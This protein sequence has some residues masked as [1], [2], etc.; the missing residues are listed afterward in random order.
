VRGHPAG[1]PE[2]ALING[3]DLIEEHPRGYRQA[4]LRR[5]NEDFGRVQGFVKLGTDS[6]DDGDRAMKI[7]DVV[8]DNQSRARFLNLRS[9]DV[10][11]IAEIDLATFQ[12]DYR[13]P[14]CHTSSSSANT[15]HGSM[16]QTSLRRPAMFYRNV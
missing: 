11:E 4:A 3:S 9:D 8:L 2:L 6:R 7:G 1:E 14:P 10:V 16:R 13:R 15:F 5:L 12:P